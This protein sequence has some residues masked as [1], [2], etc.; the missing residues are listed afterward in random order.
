MVAGGEHPATVLSEPH[1]GL[2]LGFGETVTDVD[3]HQ[4][5]LVVVEFVESAQDRV[6][7]GTADPVARGHLVAGGPQLVGE[8]REARDVPVIGMRRDRRLQ[9]DL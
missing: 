9:Q 6:V 7:L 2:G 5:H 3:G 1:D 8:Q 4:P